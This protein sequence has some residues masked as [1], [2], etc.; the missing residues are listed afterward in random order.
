MSTSGPA[1]HAPRCIED[2]VT[3]A[4]NFDHRTSYPLRIAL[5]T[6]QSMLN[7]VSAD[8]QPPTHRCC[9]CCCCCLIKT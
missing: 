1:P 7:Q 4:Q 9:C 6:A 3:D 8:L 2:I 5:R